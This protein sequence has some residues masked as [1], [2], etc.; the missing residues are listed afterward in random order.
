MAFW[1]AYLDF[2]FQR[3]LDGL[4][5]DNALLLL[6]H[7]LDDML[8]LHL[9]LLVALV[10]DA[11]LLGH[12]LVV[13]GHNAQFL[14]QLGLDGHK[15]D[16]GGAQFVDASAGLLVLQ[17]DGALGTVGAVQVG[18][19]LLQLSVES[20]QT[21]LGNAVLVQS[22]LQLALDILVVGLQFGQLERLLLDH[23]LEIDVGLV[24]H[25]QG[26]LQ[27]GDLDLQL[28][29]DAGHLG[30]QPGLRLNDAG[31]ELLDLNGGLLAVESN[32]IQ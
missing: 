10:A 32:N 18:A 17:L 2:D 5:L 25:I 8:Q 29:L 21:A 16:V 31:I 7:L 6:M 30:L 26:H 9:D 11:Q 12:L 14:L 1:L 15:V 24:G 13:G 4:Q 20:G 27:L 22:G 19:D 28:L 23:L 3:L